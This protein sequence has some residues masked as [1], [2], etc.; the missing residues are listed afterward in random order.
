MAPGKSR[1]NTP[2]GKNSDK[3]AQRHGAISAH[4]PDK[5]EPV[6]LLK[7]AG[8]VL[9]AALICGYL[10]ACLLFY[11]GQWQ[12]VLHPGRSKPAPGTIAGIPFEPVRFGVDESGTPQLTGWWIPVA[13]N[14]R[15][16]AETILYLPSGDGSLVDAQPTLSA[17]HSLGINIFAFDYRG[18]GQSAATH[19]DERRMKQDTASAW[20]YLTTSRALPAARIIPFGEGVG[21]S[22]AANLASI[23]GQIPGVILRSPRF[24]LTSAVS[25]DPRVHLLPVRLL[26]HDTFDIRSA[27]ASLKATKLFLL[28]EN[29]SFFDSARSAADPKIITAVPAGQISDPAS[30][31]QVARF[32]DQLPSGPAGSK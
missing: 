2:P 5:V 29:S 20:K 19:P 28:P 13:P 14:S 12:F 23:Q 25:Q 11:Q 6:W 24:D 16:A 26:F 32:L 21:A 17:L 7:A 22:L 4:S 15:Y 30:I 31:E 27:A 9:V 1:S 8:A 3:A 18:Y 10:T